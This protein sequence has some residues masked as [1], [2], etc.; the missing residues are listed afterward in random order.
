MNNESQNYVVVSVYG[1]L[2]CIWPY[3]IYSLRVHFS[4]DME[5]GVFGTYSD[6]LGPSD[7]ISAAV[8]FFSTDCFGCVQQVSIGKPRLI[9]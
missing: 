5:I 7:C 6:S 3:R 9:P 2:Y 1:S 8:Y 4:C